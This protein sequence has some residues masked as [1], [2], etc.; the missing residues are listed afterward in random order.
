MRCPSSYTPMDGWSG[1]SGG[2]GAATSAS[3]L[4]GTLRQDLA[5]GFI[6][7]VGLQPCVLGDYANKNGYQVAR[8][9]VDEAES[10]RLSQRDAGQARL[11]AVDLPVASI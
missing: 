4:R 6:L 2:V 7:S 1:D 11:S 3:K 5:P 10:G 8:E 9:Y